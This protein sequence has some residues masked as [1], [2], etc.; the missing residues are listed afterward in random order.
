MSKFIVCPTPLGNITIIEEG[1]AITHLLLPKQNAPDD[2]I[3]KE[4]PLLKEASAQ[5]SQ[6][7]AGQRQTFSLPLSPAGTAFERQVWQALLNIPYGTAVSYGEIA[8]TIGNPKACRAVG[9]A[10]SRNPIPIFIPCHR[11]IGSTG[12]L[13]G[14]TGGLDIKKAL[15][16][17]EGISFKE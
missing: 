10:N 6:Y 5:L 2:S 11:V 7:F 9:R 14:Y 12:A 1:N 13:T 8:H 15:L 4:T 16:R 3:Q 17:L